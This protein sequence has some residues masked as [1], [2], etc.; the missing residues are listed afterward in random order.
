MT[1]QQLTIL[2]QSIR[3]RLSV[4]VEEV[5]VEFPEAEEEGK[6]F[7]GGTVTSWPKFQPLFEVIESLDDMCAELQRSMRDDN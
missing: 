1:N 2:L 7:M 5:R 6:N 4:A 3:D